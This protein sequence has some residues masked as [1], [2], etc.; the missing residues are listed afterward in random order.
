MQEV[1]LGSEKE[2]SIYF[3][4]A[5]IELSKNSAPPPIVC[6]TA[7][8]D[9]TD[10]YSGFLKA[11][12]DDESAEFRKNVQIFRLDT[13]TMSHMFDTDKKFKPNVFLSVLT[14][15]SNLH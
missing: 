1:L 2:W 13:P 15:F 7:A 4:N 3:E 9:V 6:L 5:F 11:P 10:L 8:E 12:E 14:I